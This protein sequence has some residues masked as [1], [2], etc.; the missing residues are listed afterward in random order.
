MAQAQTQKK[1][2]SPK[3]KKSPKKKKNT[4]IKKE[5]MTKKLKNLISFIES[6]SCDDKDLFY[7]LVSL[8][9]ITLD[10]SIKFLQTK[11]VCYGQNLWNDIF[12]DKAAFAREVTVF[13][14]FN[15]LLS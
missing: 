11:T 4:E 6:G 14:H 12:R 10:N 8:D 5:K 1:K 2:K 9:K 7:Y 13:F 15:S 3:N